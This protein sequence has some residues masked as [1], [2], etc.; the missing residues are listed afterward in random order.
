MEV[1]EPR[2]E[3]VA[4]D[5][6]GADAP[7]PLAQVRD[8]VFGLPGVFQLVRCTS[9]GLVY[10]NPRPL[11]ADLAAYYPS[12]EYYAYRTPAVAPVG[13]EHALTGAAAA[14]HLPDY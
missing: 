12:E 1:C 5:L 9:C 14:P 4:C 7:M 13:G 6:C 2:L 8:R 10:L 11:A 3:H